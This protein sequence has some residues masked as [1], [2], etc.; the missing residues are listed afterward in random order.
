MQSAQNLSQNQTPFLVP[1]NTVGSWQYGETRWLILDRSGGAT[2]RDGQGRILEH[3]TCNQIS[4]GAGDHPLTGEQLHRIHQLGSATL[5]PVIDQNYKLHLV[6]RLFGAGKDERQKDSKSTSVLTMSPNQTSSQKTLWDNTNSNSETE[7]QFPDCLLGE[8]DSEWSRFVQTEV[9]GWPAFGNEIDRYEK[10]MAKPWIVDDP[11]RRQ[12]SDTRRDS[13]GKLGVDFGWNGPSLKRL[14]TGTRFSPEEDYRHGIFLQWEVSPSTFWPTIMRESRFKSV[15][16]HFKMAAE[17]G[18]APAM[19]EYGYIFEVGYGGSEINLTMAEKWYRSASGMG[20]AVGHYLLAQLLRRLKTGSD[21]DIIQLLTRA[22]KEDRESRVPLACYELGRIYSSGI[23]VPRDLDRAK[24][25]Y[26]LALSRDVCPP[27]ARE[28]A[29]I[30]E[31]EGNI[32]AARQYL[33][34]A[35][36][37]LTYTKRSNVRYT[38]DSQAC[39]RYALALRDGELGLTRDPHT[40]LKCLLIADRLGEPHKELLYELGCWYAGE[41]FVT[42][43]YGKLALQAF[44]KASQIVGGHEA[45]KV[46]VHLYRI[47]EFG[48]EGCLYKRTELNNLE[49]LAKSSEEGIAALAVAWCYEQGRG[50]AFSKDARL[51]KEYFNVAIEKK[52]W[53]AYFYLGVGL[54]RSDDLQ[55]ALKMYSKGAHKGDLL[56]LVRRWQLASQLGEKHVERYLRSAQEAFKKTGYYPNLLEPMDSPYCLGRLP[57]LSLNLSAI[58]PSHALDPIALNSPTRERREQLTKAFP[59]TTPWLKYQEAL[60]LTS[61]D[62]RSQAFASLFRE[63]SKQTQPTSW[64]KEV[65]ALLHLYG[66][67]VS[68]DIKKAHRLI[69]NLMNSRSSVHVVDLAAIDLYGMRGQP[70]L[71]KVV[72]MVAPLVDQSLGAGLLLLDLNFSGFLPGKLLSQI[73][74]DLNSQVVQGEG[75]LYCSRLGYLLLGG[76]GVQKSDPKEAVTLFIRGD[77]KGDLLASIN[78]AWC[79]LQGI[80]GSQDLQKSNELT[81]KVLTRATP[82]ELLH[83][84]WLCTHGIFTPKNMELATQLWEQAGKLGNKWAG[85]RAKQLG[86]LCLKSEKEEQSAKAEI[87]AVGPE[88]QDTWLELGKREALDEVDSCSL[89]QLQWE[90]DAHRKV[91]LQNQWEIDTLTKKVTALGQGSSDLRLDHLTQ[92]IEDLK[93]KMEVHQGLLAN[94]IDRINSYQVFH[95]SPN[96]FLFYHR[97]QSKLTSIFISAHAQQ[98]GFVKTGKGKLGYAGITVDLFGGAFGMIPIIGGATEK[99]TKVIGGAAQALDWARQSNQARNITNLG[100]FETI[101]KQ[102][103]KAAR[104][105]TKRFKEQLERIASQEE[106]K[107][108]SKQ[109]KT[110]LT[111]FASEMMKTGADKLGRWAI[112]RTPQSPAE[113]LA[114]FA[115]LWI[116][117]HLRELEDTEKALNYTQDLAPQFVSIIMK[118]R[119][120]GSVKKDRETWDKIKEKVNEGKESCSNWIGI[121]AVLTKT[122]EE[123]PMRE[124]FTRCGI[125]DPETGKHYAH[126]ESKCKPWKYGYCLGTVEE[127]IER[128]I[129]FE[130]EKALTPASH[131]VQK[132]VREHTQDIK[133]LEEKLERVDNWHEVQK[134]H[135]RVEEVERENQQLKLLLNSLAQHLNNTNSLPSELM[136]HFSSATV[137]VAA[138]P[139]QATNSQTASLLSGNNSTGGSEKES[140]QQKTD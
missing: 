16:D 100:P 106:V 70:D 124:L 13:R 30:C 58:P 79:H 68:Q 43:R 28:L 65:I 69:T 96:L 89:H 61:D 57:K 85:E 76:L 125:R 102:I 6:P 66:L 12:N 34:M 90:I 72:E 44:S 134:W 73:Y 136:N 78:L 51:A 36:N 55:G 63:L 47:A 114:D 22:V 29:Y 14:L 18:F 46:K 99:A 32:E 40:A 8:G 123:W 67:G 81:E 127:A 135:R 62:K 52:V 3:F 74:D 48:V 38:P 21:Q 1:P 126:G 2:L 140:K 11:I 45:S 84:G 91:I 56:C 5:H 107:R 24:E 10:G 19:C 95:A 137:G 53:A 54:E 98:G 23:G 94:K 25:L 122:G 113:D 92:A 4:I 119:P 41:R 82:Q 121:S 17:G 31:R 86:T 87:S 64:E 128:G 115:A 120:F 109:N 83:L 7:K 60:S 130:K 111:G 93:T 27:A 26:E 77:E 116:C 33:E 104:E 108:L 37:P 20:D 117:E 35:V 129:W 9:T 42:T 112:C 75:H 139:V 97:L 59:E 118:K 88:Q 80:G 101:G 39:Y 49:T 103:E 132:L 15:V 50:I 133:R 105:L 138:R 110:S 131:S 71:Q